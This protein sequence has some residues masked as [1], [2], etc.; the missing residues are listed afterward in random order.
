MVVDLVPAVAAVAVVL[1]VEWVV[2]VMGAVVVVVVAAV[3]WVMVAVIMV[4]VASVHLAPIPVLGMVP[5]F[6]I[7][8]PRTGE[9]MATST[10]QTTVVLPAVAVRP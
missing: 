4:S 10:D 8:I 5:T 3:E 1:V 2:A 6:R 9:T 7:T